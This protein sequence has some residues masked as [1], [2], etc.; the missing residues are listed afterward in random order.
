VYLSL[1]SLL[2]DNAKPVCTTSLLDVVHSRLLLIRDRYL[3][4]VH[5]HPIL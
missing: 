1:T 5:Q 2:V 3:R 4:Y